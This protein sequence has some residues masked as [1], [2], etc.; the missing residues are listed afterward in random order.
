MRRKRKWERE[1]PEKV[2]ASNKRWREN[3][4]GKTKI[5]ALKAVYGLSEDEFRELLDSTIGACPICEEE[6]GSHT[7][8]IDHDHETGE[9]RGIICRK[10]NLM[11]GRI[12]DDIDILL[13]AIEY[14]KK[15]G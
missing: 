1:N 15:E 6:F 4:R 5:A 7:A 13:N 3:N 2:K 8:C 12:N 9:I 14:L 11:L 10:C